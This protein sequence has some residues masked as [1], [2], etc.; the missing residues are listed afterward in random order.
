MS[1]SLK[2]CVGVLFL[3]SLGWVG[4]NLLAEQAGI[5]PWSKN[6][7]YWQYNGKPV[8]LIGGSKDDNLFQIPDLKEHL[9]E[10]VAVGANYI[11]NTMSDRPDK[12]F[13][14]YP[15]KKLE[16]GKYDL[17]QWNDEYWQRFENLL[18]WTKERNIFVQI[19]VWD[20]F[21]YSRDNWEPHPYNPKNNI[22]YT[23]EESGFAEHYPDH[24][25]SNKQPFF[26]TTP[27]QRNNKVVF[28]YQERFVDKMLSYSLQYDHVLYCIDNETSGEEEWAK[29][30]A[31][32]IRRKAAQIG[33]KVCV[34]E[35]WDDWDLKAPRHR[36]TLDH[37]ELYA[38]ADISQNNH[39][40]G[41][42]H[43]DN[44]QWV[45]DYVK[46]QPRPLNSVKIYGADTGRYGNDQDGVERFWRLLLGGAAAVRFHR[47]DSGLGLNDKAK[48]S[49]QAARKV[50][51]LVPWWELRPAMELLGNREAN[52]AYA[53]AKPGEACVVFFCN[54][55]EVTVNLS[56]WA[57]GEAKLRWINVSDGQWGPEGTTKAGGLVTLKTPQAGPWV[58]VIL[59]NSP[60]VAARQTGSSDVKRSVPAT[61]ISW[62]EKAPQKQTAHGVLR[63]C[64]A[65]P[66]YFTDDS[67]KAILMVGS[68]T[69]NNLVDM[70]P[71][72][73]PPAFDFPAYLDFLE[74]YNHNFIR[75]WTWELL[76][77]DTAGN[78]EPKAQ[79]H[80]AFPHPWKRTGPGTARDGKPKFDLTQF[81]E[82]YFSRLRERVKLAQA[83]GIYVSIM[84]FE[85]WGLQFSP[86]AYESHPFHPD[87]NINGIKGDLDGDGKAVEIHELKDPRILEIQKAYVRHVIDTVNEFDNV[88]YEISNENHPPSTDW[89]Y[90]MIR[91]IKAY[92]SEKG[93]QHPVGM[94]FQYR[95]GSN[96]TLFDSP[97]D[98][99]SPNPEGGYRDD[100][101]AADGSKVIINDTDHLWG[102]GGN[103]TWVW[104]S[105]MRGMNPIFMDPY[106]GRVLS[107]G[108]NLAW[109]ED[110]RKAMG[111]VR[112]WSQRVD[113]TSMT[114]RPDLASTKYCLANPGK[115]YLVFFPEKTDRGEIQL[116]P[117][118]YE[119]RWF[120]TRARQEQPN[121]TLATS[122]ESIF[123]K[124]PADGEWLLHVKAVQ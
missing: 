63:V 15:F 12:G 19:E 32:H 66:R 34:T 75:M 85:G 28:P 37:P 53:A 14:V 50:E 11:R 102:I 101:P 117:G 56:Q 89:R 87:N 106:D 118:S 52:E 46:N 38:F 31:E 4:H 70:G 96:K 72:D 91:F 90:E 82:N 13:E 24:P 40:K 39:Q 30:W 120:D 8:M 68:H 103:R 67:G 18:K 51:S 20:R 7:Y 22:N 78:R 23:Y 83:R 60:A 97:A 110:V 35:M 108:S 124:V 94:T 58:A 25:G 57:A 2:R 48:A 123:V 73:P 116:V 5:S 76:T 1:R 29:Y 119:L 59:R 92:E 45:R 9:D 100:P 115:E 111:D 44:F 41:Q 54:G 112:K 93:R 10:M 95:G 6:P 42:T 36:R 88:L 61:L 99:I 77:W 105:F 107:R 69:W 113:L 27:Y 26:F 122:K 43:W 109:T 74:K 121:G 71:G 86:N 81:D 65:N 3:F 55:G 21:D 64:P 49:I 79:V 104:K 47:P 80:V 33:K 17:N 114:P 62:A 16:N 98:W 84:L